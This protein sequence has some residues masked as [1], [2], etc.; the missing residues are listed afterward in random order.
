[1]RI[2]ILL[3][4]DVIDFLCAFVVFILREICSNLPK[5][6]GDFLMGTICG[7]CISDDTTTASSSDPLAAL[8][9]SIGGVPSAAAN[10][11]IVVAFLVMVVIAGVF[12]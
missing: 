3:L 10:L 5:P 7:S 4:I 12:F 6:V 1:M 9:K 2:S 11:F 8:S